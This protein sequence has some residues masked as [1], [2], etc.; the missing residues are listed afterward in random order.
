MTQQANG[1]NSIVINQLSP[2]GGRTMI[3][4]WSPSDQKRDGI[5]RN[6]IDQRSAIG[7]VFI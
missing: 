3:I 4:T 1:K 2:A 6:L 7:L 5:D